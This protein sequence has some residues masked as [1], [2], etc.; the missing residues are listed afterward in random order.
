MVPA[1]KVWPAPKITSVYLWALLWYSP[2]KFRSISGSLSP[3]KPRKVSKGMSKPSFFR[4]SPQTGQYL[5][6]MSQPARPE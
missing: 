2:E 5:S 1:R 3:L 6:G 4:S